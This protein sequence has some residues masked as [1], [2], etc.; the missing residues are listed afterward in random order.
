MTNRRWSGALRLLF[1]VVVALTTAIVAGPTEVAGAEGGVGAFI[2]GG[3]PIAAGQYP[4]LAAILIDAPGV[5]ARQR[6]VCSG[7]VVHPRWIM[8]A[9]HCS[10]LLLFGE[11]V[12]AQVGSRDLGAGTAQ[13]LKVNRA[14]VHQR[15]WN[16]GV[17]YDIALFHT[18]APIN[19][20]VARLAGAADA[21]LASGGRTAT[22]VGWGFTKQLGILQ[23]P[24]PKA[25]PP[26]RANHVTMPIVGDAA[27]AATYK[28]FYP[29]YFVAG[30][31]VCA[32][33]EGRN[34]CYGDSGG[35]LYATDAKGQLVQIGVTSRGAGCA[36]KLFP[37]IFTEVRRIQG[38]VNKWT[39]TK[40]T[41]RVDLGFPPI[42]GE[43]PLP[44]SRV[45]VC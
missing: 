22:A 41:N 36:T 37:A 43:P 7:T 44:P 6:L 25:K 31:D 42:P 35:P 30:S 38:W 33:A 18:M 39:T 9:G 34:V 26:R 14:V 19:A 5:P 23:P 16:R 17:S 40:C 24:P 12:L 21:A 32:G 45:F 10:D 4:S 13:T 28:D 8:T 27:C 3:D 1:V 15:Y 20:P 29:G 11:P 2:V